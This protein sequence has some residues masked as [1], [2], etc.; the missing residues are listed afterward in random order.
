MKK[1]FILSVLLLTSC[2]TEP[3][4]FGMPEAQFKQL[5]P[6]QQTQVIDSYN[7]Q[8]E[9]RTQNEPI[10]DAIDSLRFLGTINSN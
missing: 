6:S 7:R 8:K 5:S 9:I 2:A 3:T 4:L 10:T 1:S